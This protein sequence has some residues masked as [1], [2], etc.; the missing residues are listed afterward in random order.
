MLN[1]KIIEETEDFTLVE[2]RLF[3]FDKIWKIKVPKQINNKNITL[4]KYIIFIAL[5]KKE[6]EKPGL[7][8]EF[9]FFE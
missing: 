7:D 2:A 9:N 3:G 4:E 1:I 8:L 6:E 5:K